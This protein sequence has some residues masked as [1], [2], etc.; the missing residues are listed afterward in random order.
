MKLDQYN[1][2]TL[3]VLTERETIAMQLLEIRYHLYGSSDKFDF[4]MAEVANNFIGDMGL[5][6]SYLYV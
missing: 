2:Q 6:R 5:P 1:G 4:L 3:Q